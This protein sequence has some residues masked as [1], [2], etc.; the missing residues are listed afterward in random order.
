M[1]DYG[2][3]I[4]ISNAISDKVEM[5]VTYFLSLLFSFIIIFLVWNLIWKLFNKEVKIKHTV[6][7]GLIFVLG[8]ILILIL[9]PGAFH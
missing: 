5:Y 9:F 1:S 6:L 7:F 8:A 3:H 4:P 2:F